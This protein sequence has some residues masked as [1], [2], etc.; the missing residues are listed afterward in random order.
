MKIWAVPAAAA[1]RWPKVII[2]TRIKR[3]RKFENMRDMEE[4]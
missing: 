3:I 1:G 4:I 2:P